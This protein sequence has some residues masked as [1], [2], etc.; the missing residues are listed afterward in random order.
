MK[1]LNIFSKQLYTLLLILSFTAITFAQN[2][3]RTIKIGCDYAYYPYEFINEKHEADGFDIDIIK[4]IGKE[5]NL[6]LEIKAGNWFKI[7]TELENGKLD[8][9]AGMYYLPDRAEKVNF[10]MPYIIITHSIFVKDGDYWQSL[11]DVRDEKK[12]K[13]VVENSSILHSYLTTAGIASNRILPVENQLDAL[14]ILSETPNSVALLPDLQGKYIANKNGFDNIITVGL[15][16]LPREYSIAVNKSDTTLLNQINDAITRINQNGSY[17]RIYNKWFGSDNIQTTK[18]IKLST[19]EAILIFL[20]VILIAYFIYWNRKM[21]VYISLNTDSLNQELHNK[22][23][24]LDKLNKKEAILRKITE[25]TPYP[26]AMLDKKGSFT[27]VNRLFE[28]EF[29]YTKKEVQNIDKW[30]PMFFS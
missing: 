24:V 23:K 7:K 6:K 10:S 8:A 1:L 30:I 3:T 28:D 22:Q 5:L 15:P 17:D 21:R 20:L 26:I 14:K 16:I 29:G 9:I 18:L 27:Y 11:K 12:L 13:V 25:N 2:S 4:A 19:L